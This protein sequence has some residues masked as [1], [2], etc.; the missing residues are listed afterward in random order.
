MFAAVAVFVW[1]RVLRLSDDMANRRR[2]TLISRLAK[3]E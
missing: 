1:L 2:D 3:A